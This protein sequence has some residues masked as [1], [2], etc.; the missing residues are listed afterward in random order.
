MAVADCE[1][2][3]AARIT[4]WRTA[5]RGLMPQRYLDA[6]SME[7]DAERRRAYLADADRSVLDVVAERAGEV[8]GWGCCGPYREDG[9][10]RTADGE[11]YALYVHPDHWS[12]GAGR[13]ILAELTA[14]AAADGYPRLLLWVLKGNDRARR[15]YE[16]AGF[17]PDGAEEDFVA[18]GVAVPEVRY[19]LRLA[20]PVR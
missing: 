8:I 15:F 19:A 20:S 16:R 1:A 2:V 17:A 12:T 9:G 3:A 10:G 5:Y 11:V 6:L 14:R 18:D 13:L 4:G 7:A